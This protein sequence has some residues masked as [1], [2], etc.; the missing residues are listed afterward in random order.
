MP[1]R[2]VPLSSPLFAMLK[3]WGIAVICEVPA[4]ELAS[5]AEKAGVARLSA[6]VSKMGSW[7]PAAAQ[8]HYLGCR[9][10]SN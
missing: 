1:I 9:E 3:A 10:N 2:C 4:T 8:D 6:V 7:T 5:P